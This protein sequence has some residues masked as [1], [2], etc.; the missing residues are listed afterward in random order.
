MPSFDVV[1]EVD[2]QEVRNA[3]D[4]ALREI[5]TRFDFKGSDTRIDWDGHQFTL[6]ADD[7]FK[8][9]QAR[10][11]LYLRLA[12]RGVDMK[13]VSAQAVE[14]VSSGRARQLIDVRSGI[15]A[16]AARRLVRLVKDSRV[17]VQAAVQGEQLRISGK[18][19]DDLQQIMALLRRE[20]DDIALQFVNFRD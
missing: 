3:L 5:G 7:E 15:D 6:V 13:A 9:G 18:K 16:D 17:R 14:A 12:K 10:D 1:S 2:V 20:A 8:L 19:R 4:Q 11:I